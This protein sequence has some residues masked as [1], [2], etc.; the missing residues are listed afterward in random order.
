MCSLVH[1]FCLHII[2]HVLLIFRSWLP[3]LQE[4]AQRK[5]EEEERKKAEDEEPVL[6]D[7]MVVLRGNGPDFSGQRVREESYQICLECSKGSPTIL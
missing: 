4:E 5:K 1:S 6:V 3:R 7:Q 2:G